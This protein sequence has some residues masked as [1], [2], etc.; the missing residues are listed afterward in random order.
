[1][2]IVR[3]VYHHLCEKSLNEE[4]ERRRKKEERKKERKKE[5]EEE[6]EIFHFQFSP[7]P[8]PQCHIT[9]VLKD[10]VKYPEGGQSPDLYF[11]WK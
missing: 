1:M 7:E 11:G 2:V 5:E 6:E 9:R 3:S 4:E 10:H 8:P